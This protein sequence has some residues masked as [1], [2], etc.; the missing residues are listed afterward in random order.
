[1]NIIKL[2]LVQVEI[3]HFRKHDSKATESC[4]Q[5]LFSNTDSL[6]FLYRNNHTTMVLVSQQTLEFQVRLGQYGANINL[7]QMECQPS[8]NIF[9]IFFIT[10][11][12]PDAV[13]QVVE[14]A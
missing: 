4:T 12:I 6:V 7:E 2:T 10:F 1:M 14:G 5:T 9:S 11:E 8:K 3:R 13:S